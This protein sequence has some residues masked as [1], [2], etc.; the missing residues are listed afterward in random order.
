MVKKGNPYT[1]ST[2]PASPRA[3]TG[4][5]AYKAGLMVKVAPAYT[6][7]TCAV[8]GH[9]DKANRKTQ[10]TFQCT[11]CGHT[12]NADRNAAVNIQDRSQPRRAVNQADGICPRL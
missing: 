1:Y 5:L 6:S 4:H 12:A 9:V 3:A 10:A 11:A 7:Q 2:W 8:C